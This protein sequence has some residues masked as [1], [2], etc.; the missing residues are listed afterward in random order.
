MSTE[1]NERL[2]ISRDDRAQFWIVD[3]RDQV[4]DLINECYVKRLVSDRLQFSPIV[5]APF[6]VGKFMSVMMR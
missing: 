6:A 4:N 1:F 5:P 3:T 2:S